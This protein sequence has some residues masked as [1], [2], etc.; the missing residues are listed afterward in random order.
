MTGI[1]QLIADLEAAEVGSRGWSDRVLLALG[2]TTKK[3]KRY[4]EELWQSPRD[5]HYVDVESAVG[6]Y[7]RPDPTR[8]VDDALT[9]MPERFKNNWE[10]SKDG[11]CSA[12][13]YTEDASEI[14]MGNHDDSVVLALCIALLSAKQSDHDSPVV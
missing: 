4:L 2:W 6:P 10:L 5:E 3:S 13:L 7:N 1:E 9:L 8:S 14:V 11:Y 12:R